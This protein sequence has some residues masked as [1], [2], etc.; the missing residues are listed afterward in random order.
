MAHDSFVTINHNRQL[1]NK[2][3]NDT[4]HAYVNRGRQK[5]NRSEQF[6]FFWFVTTSTI[7]CRFYA[8]QG[9]TDITLIFIWDDKSSD[10]MGDRFR[11]PDQGTA[12][13]FSHPRCGGVDY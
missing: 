2:V 6:F 11:W 3:R 7:N 8:G 9:W 12:Q 10:L 4:L 1:P 13:V 5:N